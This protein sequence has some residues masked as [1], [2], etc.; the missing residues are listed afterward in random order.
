MYSILKLDHTNDVT[1]YQGISFFV[2][3]SIEN[4]SRTKKSVSFLAVPLLVLFQSSIYLNINNETLFYL[5]DT[6]CFQYS[7]SSSPAA[8]SNKN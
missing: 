7:S 2:N 1:Y 8:I 3:K 4:L 5:C 6:L